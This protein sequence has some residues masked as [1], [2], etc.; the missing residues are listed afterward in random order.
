[1]LSG[2]TDRK[3]E[4]EGIARRDAELAAG[5]ES[6]IYEALINSPD[7]DIQ[8]LAMTGLLH[9]AQP[10]KKKGGLRGWLGEMESSPILPQLQQLI[11]TPVREQQPAYGLPSTQMQG[12]ISLPPGDQP[13]AMAD[14]STVEPG[15]PP[16]RPVESRMTMTAVPPPQI[17][18]E[19]VSRR[20]QVF[21]TPEE[22][23]LLTKKASAQ[24]DVEGEVAGL[25]ASGFS[26][27]EARELVKQSYL[28]RAAGSAT[29][30]QSVAG[31]LADGTPAYGVF[32]RLNGGYDDPITK[33]PLQGFRPRTTT[34][35]TSMG[36]DREA[37]A[38]TL[39]GLPF[40]RLTQP[41]Q[42]QV[43]QAETGR[44]QEMAYARGTGTGTA[45][46]ETE[47]DKPIGPTA[48][49]MYNTDPTT[50]L[51]DLQGRVTLTPEQKQRVYATGQ[52]DTL[53]SDIE[54]LLP[55]VFP[56]VQP[57]FVGGIKTALS[58][59]AQRL[60]RDTDLA[61]LDAS[62][63]AALA[64][65]AQLSG[66]PGSR[67]SDKDIALARSTLGSLSPS[68][69][70]GDTLATAQA[71]LGVLKELLAKSQGSVPTAPTVQSSIGTA[72]PRGTAPLAPRS[73]PPTAAPGNAPAGY[74]VSP[75]GTLLLNGQPAP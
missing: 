60:G 34:G 63:N 75:D 19:T 42:A 15:A 9:S 14:S 67:L 22:Q 50:S 20:R 13:A 59:G 33:Q 38:R 41:Q 28:R 44:A 35:S 39:F 23:M 69:F 25:V 1:M 16:P 46:I 3:G 73:A 8:A 61:Q 2:F 10:T 54:R 17:G 43:M 45:S 26:E 66:Q 40:A 29:P 11:Q 64:Q 21:R 56:D 70:G 37:I 74:T 52:V 12:Q 71:R 58:L 7:P 55:Q 30:Y 36:V 47:L 49:A 27:P 32:N 62:I 68:L 72:P 53:I 48:A 57:G 24:G 6:K 4:V 5:R 18:T 65:V 51:R 31:E